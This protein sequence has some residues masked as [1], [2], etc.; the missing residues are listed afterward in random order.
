MVKA[1]ALIVMIVLA[2]SLTGCTVHP[3]GEKAL[4]TSAAEAGAQFANRDSELP[5]DATIEQ[6]VDHVLLANAELEQRYWEWKSAIEQIPQSGTQPSNLVIFAG[7]PITHGSTAFDRTTVTVANDPMNDILWPSKL[8]VAAERALD[9]AKAAGV[10]FQKA[11]YELRNKVIS[12][13]Y[14]YALTAEL[15]RLEES[16]SELLKTVASATEA[17]N[18]AGTAGQQDLLKARNEADLSLNDIAQMKSQL[19]SQRALLNALLSRAPD[20]AIRAPTTMPSTR[21]VTASDD[22]LLALA[23]ERNPELT[24]LAHELAGKKEGIQLARLQYVPDFSVSVGTDLGGVAQSLM[25]MVTV[26]ILRHE[27]IDAAISQAEANLR[28][29]EAM[30]RQTRN[31]IKAQIVG[32]IATFRDADRQLNLF[33][34]T[35]LPRAQQVVALARTA[36]ESGHATLLDL[37]DSQRSLISIQKLIANLQATREKRLADIEAI[38]AT[39][40][41]TQR[42]GNGSGN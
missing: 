15:I 2:I 40:L 23:A 16:N 9:D 30:R 5:A 20:A 39:Q 6:I 12:A 27:A 22:G 24:A 17:R 42:D 4:R 34:Q 3:A 28:A 21:P 32:D 14:D 41:V 29:T 25:G 36:Y 11:M 37:L 19:V 26:P 10:R 7:V 35:I 8:S 1:S 13:Y 38:A 33:R 31:D 18:R